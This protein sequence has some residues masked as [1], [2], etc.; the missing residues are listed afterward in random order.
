MSYKNVT[1][2]PQEDIDGVA[3]T[4]SDVGTV[5]TQMLASGSVGAHLL[6]QGR[7]QLLSSSSLNGGNSVS[8]GDDTLYFCLGDWLVSGGVATTNVFDV[9]LTGGVA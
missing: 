8:S 5:S 3:I 4:Q 2:I 6:A 9:E 1:P 7:T